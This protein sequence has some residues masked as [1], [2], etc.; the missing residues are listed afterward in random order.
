VGTDINYSAIDVLNV[1]ATATGD[2]LDAAFQSGSD[3]DTVNLSGWTGGDQFFLR[4]TDELILGAVPTGIQTINLFGDAPGNPT[5]RRERYLRPAFGL[6][7]GT[8]LGLASADPSQHQTLIN[9][10]GGKPSA[11]TGCQRSARRRAEPR[12]PAMLPPV[13][14]LRSPPSH[15]GPVDRRPPSHRPVNEE[16]T[17]SM[18]DPDRRRDG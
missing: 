16:A 11:V 18:K 8:P 10:D 7:P 3:L 17:L 13:M 14:W 1:T 4:T 6:L 15:F 9:I 5:Q 2:T 12:R